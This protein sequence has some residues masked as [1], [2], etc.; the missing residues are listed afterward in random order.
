MANDWDKVPKWA[1]EQ[2]RRVEAERDTLLERARQ[3]AAGGG[4]ARI[5]C[6]DLLDSTLTVGFPEHSRIRFALDARHS[7]DVGLTYDG[8]YAP[9]IE[10]SSRDGAIVVS[11][12][13]CNLIRV[14][15][16]DR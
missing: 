5:Q 14:G 3:S 13:A 9:T 2:Y 4:D 15:S 6:L 12:L 10:V 11:P 1:R 7:I 8:G 16:E